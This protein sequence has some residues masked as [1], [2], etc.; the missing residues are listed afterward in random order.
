ME[1]FHDL[2]ALALPGSG[3]HAIV[4]TQAMRSGANDGNHG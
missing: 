3:G 4:A 1:A 2:S